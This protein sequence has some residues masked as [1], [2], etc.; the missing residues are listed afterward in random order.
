MRTPRAHHSDPACNPYHI[1]QLRIIA[2][3]GSAPAPSASAA[4][5]A[6]ETPESLLRARD[7]R[8]RA[9][10]TAGSKR[11]I[12][13]AGAGSS[14]ELSSLEQGQHPGGG[15]Q[16]GGTQLVAE[17]VQISTSTLGKVRPP[18]RGE[19]G[20]DDPSCTYEAEPRDVL[21]G[22][23]AEARQEAEAW[24][25]LLAWLPHEARSDT[26][27]WE[28]VA[29]LASADE[30]AYF[31]AQLKLFS[32]LC[33]ARNQLSSASVVELVPLEALLL[34]LAPQGQQGQQ[35]QQGRRRLLPRDQRLCCELLVNVYLD[36]CKLDATQESL[37]SP[38]YLWESLPPPTSPEA[39]LAYLNNSICGPA[40]Q[41]SNLEAEESSAWAREE[42]GIPVWVRSAAAAGDQ[43]ARQ[44]VVQSSPARL[45]SSNAWVSEAGHAE[46]PPYEAAVLPLDEAHVVSQQQRLL[47]FVSDALSDEGMLVFRSLLGVTSTHP[48][49]RARTA[50]DK[51]RL[52]F[53]LSVLRMQRLMAADGMYLPDYILPPLEV[54]DKRGERAA[55]L[56]A[57]ASGA[58]TMSQG[59]EAVEAISAILE[60]LAP[61]RKLEAKLSQVL[62]G[63]EPQSFIDTK[64]HEE[65]RWSA[66]SEEEV[67]ELLS[68]FYSRTQESDQVV[69][70]AKLEV[71]RTLH[72]IYDMYTD[73]RIKTLVARYRQLFDEWI[74]SRMWRKKGD[75]GHPLKP[76]E[77]T[78]PFDKPD[79]DSERRLPPSLHHQ[80]PGL[81]AEL[82]YADVF[83]RKCYLSLKPIL[84]DSDV[85]FSEQG[86]EAAQAAHGADKDAQ[87]G[88][89]STA[90]GSELASLSKRLMNLTLYE[91]EALT[92]VACRL[93]QR[94]HSQ[95]DEVRS[96]L[97]SLRFIVNQEDAQ[98]LQV[99]SAARIRFAT[100]IATADTTPPQWSHHSNKASGFV[101]FAPADN[102]K[103]EAA[104]RTG[105]PYT[106]LE[107]QEGKYT[108]S[109]SKMGIVS[110]KG[111]VGRAPKPIQR[112]T[113]YSDLLEILD[114]H[115]SG[116]TPLCY[117]RLND[118]VC[119]V[120]GKPFEAT[121]Q[122][123]WDK[124]QAAL[125]ADSA[126]PEWWH[127]QD[128]W[129]P[130]WVPIQDSLEGGNQSMMIAEGWKD[131]VLR[132]L[133]ARSFTAEVV[134]A[135]SCDPHR[136]LELELVASCYR[137]LYYLCWDHPENWQ[138]FSN[139]P[140]LR[141]LFAQMGELAGVYVRGEPLNWWVCKLLEEIVVDNSEANRKLDGSHIAQTVQRLTI[142]GPSRELRRGRTQYVQLL[143]AIV[144]DDIQ[145]LTLRQVQV[146]EE[147]SRVKELAPQ[148][149]ARAEDVLLF[150][151]VDN[152][153]CNRMQ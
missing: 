86:E 114:D 9:A 61:I 131:A 47:A 57:L 91:D 65:G 121:D 55:R 129:P 140:T 150:F 119:T 14:V 51:E 23:E 118:R 24:V 67:R 109:L 37:V 103:L 15:T 13:A 5:A 76:F 141:F 12:E 45:V 153:G 106:D 136:A 40:T 72:L 21:V 28:A 11:A 138:P 38:L 151:Q 88:T 107:L 48:D 134:Q 18:Y 8:A 2:S 142:D 117:R 105:P 137:M 133:Q 66:V 68:V 62:Q 82:T 73:L 26:G 102:A 92:A 97:G 32:E 70:E 7:L 115:E 52:L 94:R 59:A 144:E 64:L 60:G 149:G 110:T 126:P 42:V 147:L 83:E 104:W 93:L 56:A 25:D 30:A 90:D 87:R 17:L 77:E 19:A 39:R 69:V 33:F 34:L 75:D 35:G 128:K 125:H 41:L 101:N 20:E 6:K 146:I 132:W 54:V 84:E 43:G 63:S 81:D 127:A 98:T 10:R 99:I 3:D 27:E 79:D 143:K 29:G 85:L 116:M 58:S 4:S 120:T 1:P 123:G 78:M 22:D 36:S 122:E 89:S 148:H 145:P 71:C 96:R 74:T 46:P 95:R 152:R 111:R 53:N 49:E 44:I 108:I 130:K 135:M 80:Y 112:R 100:V 139:G 31:R 50:E 113:P 16:P 124:H